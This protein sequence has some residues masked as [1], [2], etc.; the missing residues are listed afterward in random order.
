MN[1]Y[2]FIPTEKPPDFHP[3]ALQSNIKSRIHEVNIL[4]IQF[5]PEQFNRLTESLEVYHLPLPQE[6]DHIIHI[7][8][9]TEPQDVIVC[10]SCLLFCQ[11]VP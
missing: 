6:L 11:G 3:V 2:P 1:L 7:R 9:I 4:L 10:G 5:I 8:I